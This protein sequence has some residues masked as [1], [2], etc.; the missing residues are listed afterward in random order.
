VAVPAGFQTRHYN[1]FVVTED[2]HLIGVLQ[3]L[4]MV[5]ADKNHRYTHPVTGK[6]MDPDLL[7]DHSTQ[8]WLY[9]TNIR[10]L[11]RPT[12][13]EKKECDD[14]RKKLEEV[15]NENM[16]TRRSPAHKEAGR[17]RLVLGLTRKIETLQQLAEFL[18]VN[19]PKDEWSEF[20][21]TL[22]REELCRIVIPRRNQGTQKKDQTNEDYKIEQAI[23][24]YPAITEF[25]ASVID[26]PASDNA[27]RASVYILTFISHELRNDGPE[28]Y[29]VGRGWFAGMTGQTS[30]TE[31]LKQTQGMMDFLLSNEEKYKDMRDIEAYFKD[32]SIT[33]ASTTCANLKAKIIDAGRH[34]AHEVMEKPVS[35]AGLTQ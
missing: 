2:G 27:K 7:N 29:S 31:V 6:D 18:D 23:L 17:K 1:N 20:L 21:H 15:I 12:Q 22:D 28:F 3:G 32:K 9:A 30:K 8:A 4:D 5:R 35:A 19:V 25:S 10:N 34:C 16:A 33:F 11:N 24:A 26:W 14:I 13:E